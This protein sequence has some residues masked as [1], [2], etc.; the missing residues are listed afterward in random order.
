MSKV[1]NNVY[2]WLSLLGLLV[3]AFTNI[4]LTLLLKVL[5]LVL[6]LLTFLLLLMS[7]L[8]CMPWVGLPRL[9]QVQVWGGA[10]T[11]LLGVQSVKSP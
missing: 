4:T 5:L 2:I 11:G 8:C 7:L 3:T 10:C 9:E 6:L 1:T